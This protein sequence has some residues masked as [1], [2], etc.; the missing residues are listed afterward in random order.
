M[1][2]RNS[3]LICF[4]ASFAF[5]ACTEN[6]RAPEQTAPPVGDLDRPTG[7]QALPTGANDIPTPDTGIV[8]LHS[9]VGSGL[10]FQGVYD[11][12]SGNVHYFMR[13]FPRGNVAMVAGRQEPD[14]PKDLRTMLTENV[15]SGKN[16]IH[17]VPVTQ[18]GD[19]LF[20]TTMAN[21]GAIIYSGV[22]D[23]DSLRFLKHSK[24]TGKKGVVSYVF[25]P[26]G[27][28]PH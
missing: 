18:R 25:V 21:R 27:A 16:N 8:H 11:A 9:L 6:D 1:T 15:Q 26:D 24:A 14:D 2:M 28:S 12:P 20:F 10:K 19:S 23:G 22:V 3:F 17:N 4:L 5:A 7:D 13:F